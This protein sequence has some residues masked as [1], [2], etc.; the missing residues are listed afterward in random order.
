MKEESLNLRHGPA[1]GW[2]RLRFTVAYCGTPWKGWQSQE[3]G[4]GIQDELNAAIRKAVRIETGV[5]GSG[6]TDAGVQP[7][8]VFITPNAT[9]PGRRHPVEAG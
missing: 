3:G 1:P 4:G 6:R 5:Q 9:P 8:R 7:E 2:K